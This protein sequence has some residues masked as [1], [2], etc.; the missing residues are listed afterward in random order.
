MTKVAS[1]GHIA[2]NEPAPNLPIHSHVAPLA[3]ETVVR[4]A[5]EMEGQPVAHYGLTLGMAQIMSGAKVVLLA[6]GQHKESAVRKMLTG[7]I[8]TECPA[9]L[10]HLHPNSQLI[11]DELAFGSIDLPH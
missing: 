6:S 1:T 11:V 8:D 9:S 7:P 10:L 4:A 3:P 5:K 2:L